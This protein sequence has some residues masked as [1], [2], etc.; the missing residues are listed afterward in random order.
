M[1]PLI[2]RVVDGYHSTIFAYGQTGSGKTFTIEGDTG[3]NEGLIPRSI[4]NLFRSIK[5]KQQTNSGLSFK[6]NLSFLQIYMYKDT[7]IGALRTEHYSQVSNQWSERVAISAPVPEPETYAML[8][9]GLGLMGAVA[10]RRKNTA[11]A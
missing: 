5:N 9:A 7:A 2:N 6:V 10:R 4:I 8:L 3:A 11:N 1:D